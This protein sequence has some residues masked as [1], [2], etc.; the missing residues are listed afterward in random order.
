MKSIRLPWW[1]VKRR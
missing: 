1:T